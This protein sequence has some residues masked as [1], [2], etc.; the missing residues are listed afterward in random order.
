MEHDE[1][2]IGRLKHPQRTGNEVPETEPEIEAGISPQHLFLQ[3]SATPQPCQC[4][5]SR[6]G[7]P[8]A[9]H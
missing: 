2:A 9:E 7:A 3:R 1:T 5:G 4:E 6:P 8:T